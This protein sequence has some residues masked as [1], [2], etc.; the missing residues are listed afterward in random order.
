MCPTW[1]STFSNPSVTLHWPLNRR[2]AKFCPRCF[3][4]GRTVTWIILPSQLH[5]GYWRLGQ[6]RASFF[7]FTII[8]FSMSKASYWQVPWLWRKFRIKGADSPRVPL[9][10]R[11]T[12]CQQLQHLQIAAGLNAGCRLEIHTY[13]YMDRSPLGL[14]PCFLRIDF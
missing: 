12:P 4:C 5:C 11:C 1:D 6:W 3:Q 8:I 2:R 10:V 14:L 13:R 9:T 7:F